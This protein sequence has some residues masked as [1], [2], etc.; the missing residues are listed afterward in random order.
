MTLPLKMA[1]AAVMAALF[2]VA[3]AF[4][5]N[6][7]I[8]HAAGFAAGFTHPLSGLDHLLAMVAVG[9]WATQNQRRAVWILP[10]VFSMMVMAGL[11]LGITGIR[12]PIVES[13]IAGSVLALGLL[14]AFA[15]RLPVATAS[16]LVGGFALLHGLAHGIEMQSGTSVGMYAAGLML[17]TLVLHI[18]GVCAGRA[19]LSNRVTRVVGA[20]VAA[21]GAWLLAFA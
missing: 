3:P 13:G 8:L 15:V 9:W 14:I 2:A 6:E 16:T 21:T 7:G 18:T 5:H 4:A 12:I 1:G 20:A 10:L 19:M 11:I 17:A